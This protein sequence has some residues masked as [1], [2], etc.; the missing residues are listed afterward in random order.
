MYDFLYD[1]KEIGHYM[2]IVGYLPYLHPRPAILDVGCGQGRLFELLQALTNY[3]RY[4]GLDLSESAVRQAKKSR[5][6]DRASF[7]TADFEVWEAAR[8]FD[9]IIF[10]ETL[11]FSDH[12][13]VLLRRYTQFLEP[14]GVFIVSIH[15]HFGYEQIWDQI[16][17]DYQVKAGDK[18]QNL[19]GQVWDVRVLQPR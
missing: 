1:M 15:E 2:I 14:D 7:E 5:R 18:V 6:D 3:R 13:R 9:V 16:A 12:P 17:D 4:H 11:Y 8:K 19:L 10:N